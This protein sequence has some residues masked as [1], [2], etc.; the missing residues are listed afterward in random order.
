M[1]SAGEVNF[2]MKRTALT[3]GGLTQPM[4]ARSLMESPQCVDKGLVQRF[5]W[6]FPRP[7][8]SSY[9]ELEPASRSFCQ[10]LGKPSNKS[11]TVLN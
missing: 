3:V 7:S 9:S 2:R 6:I 5:L 10:F 11:S 4:V 1:H 8:Y